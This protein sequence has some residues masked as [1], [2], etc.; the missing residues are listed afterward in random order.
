M[1]LELLAEFKEG[2]L[3]L[4]G[5]VNVSP[6]PLLD[7]SHAR[8]SCSYA[9]LKHFCKALQS[10]LLI[11]SWRV[12]HPTGRD[13]SYYSKVNNVYPRIDHI[14]VDRPTLKLL[15]SASIG[16]ITISDH[17]LVVLALT[18]SSDTHRAWRLNENLLDDTAVVAKV[19]DVI[20]HYFKENTTDDHC[21][22][23]AWE[24]H[25]AVVRGELTSLSSKLKK[26][27]STQ[28]LNSS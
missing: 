17:T 5:D 16:N 6:D 2:F 14:S 19:A 11:D 12:L 10:H 8:P 9:F 23:I 24:G 26:N 4:G 20:T 3:V 15:Q 27:A 21:K 25:K 22:G 13:F 28:F 18:L 7:T 1:A